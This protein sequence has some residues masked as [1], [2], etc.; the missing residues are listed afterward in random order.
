MGGPELEQAWG[1]HVDKEC[2]KFVGGIR[3][4]TL[5]EGVSTYPSKLLTALTVRTLV[6]RKVVGNLTDRAVES[7]ANSTDYED[8]KKMIRR[9][10][11]RLAQHKTLKG[12]AK[13][14]AEKRGYPGMWGEELL[15]SVVE[16]TTGDEHLLEKAFR[17]AFE[18][19]REQLHASVRK[20][21][22]N[23]M[24]TFVDGWKKKQPI[25]LQRY[26]GLNGMQY[27][28]VRTVEDL[29]CLG[30]HP[31]LEKRAGHSTCGSRIQSMF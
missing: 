18:G 6:V 30:D 8:W 24:Q 23:W 10:V 16:E 13:K 26:T 14:Q 15:S 27:T 20:E 12:Y 7:I 3:Q 9:E 2:A 29:I 22:I 17:K 4:G 25:R 28:T 21:H 31:I 1:L 19:A 5:G 11:I